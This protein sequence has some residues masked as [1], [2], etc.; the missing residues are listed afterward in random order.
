MSSIQVAL[1]S[2]AVFDIPKRTRSVLFT[3]GLAG[4]VVIVVECL[5]SEKPGMIP[6]DKVL[7]FSGYLTLAGCCQP[8]STTLSPIKLAR[9]RTLSIWSP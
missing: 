8:S 3:A 2:G 1:R 5:V 4:V 9:C 7:H 6:I